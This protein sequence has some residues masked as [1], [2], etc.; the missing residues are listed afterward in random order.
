MFCGVMRLPR[1]RRKF[2]G[3]MRNSS[4]C[5]GMLRYDAKCCGILRN[6]AGFFGFLGFVGSYAECIGELRGPRK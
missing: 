3:V 1:I 6:A 5:C 2:H 4:E